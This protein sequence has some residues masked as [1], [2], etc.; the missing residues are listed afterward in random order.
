MEEEGKFYI[1]DYSKQAFA[2]E[3]E[4]L[5]K[6]GLEINNQFYLIDIPLSNF[7][8]ERCIEDG[9]DLEGNT[10]HYISYKE[11]ILKE[12]KKYL[13]YYELVEYAFI[14]LD[15]ETGRKYPVMNIVVSIRSIFGK[16]YDLSTSFNLLFKDEDWRLV[17][18]PELTLKRLRDY[19]SIREEIFKI[20]G[21]FTPMHFNSHVV[22]MQCDSEL[23]LRL[24]RKP[25]LHHRGTSTLYDSLY[26]YFYMGPGRDLPFNRWDFKLE[27]NTLNKIRHSFYELDTKNREDRMVLVI[28]KLYMILN[29]L[30]LNDGILYKKV[31]GNI[32]SYEKEMKVEY[33]W[34]NFE[35]ICHELQTK[36]FPYQMYKLNIAGL[37][38]E[39][40]YEAKERV[41]KDKRVL[42]Y[43][44]LDKN[45]IG[46]KDGVYNIKENKFIAAE[47]K[48]VYSKRGEKKE[49]IDKDDVLY[50]GYNYSNSKG[51]SIY[52]KRRYKGIKKPVE[53]LSL[54]SNK[55]ALEEF[56]LFFYKQYIIKPEG[57]TNLEKYNINVSSSDNNFNELESFYDLCKDSYAKVVLIKLLGILG[58]NK[59]AEKLIEIYGLEKI[60]IRSEKKSEEEVVKL[61][62]YISKYAERRN[63]LIKK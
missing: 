56:I 9:E 10:Y 62:I 2:T 40:I 17:E 39:G 47:P 28:W 53:W 13:Q 14:L 43:I 8:D 55:Q 26:T 58:Y 61:L 46:F 29:D 42:I 49:F 32:S 24:D 60:D 4:I 11:Y 54:I 41:I 38:Q 48:K 34:D 18:V 37:R 3:I 27:D 36:Y 15:K 5:I 1:V 51:T 7:L 6:E 31:E 20:C 59:D 19:E 21:D 63:K 16:S 12:M 44:E 22:F 45:L 30:Y 35:G 57:Y 50:K 52:I 23:R 25:Y 33:L